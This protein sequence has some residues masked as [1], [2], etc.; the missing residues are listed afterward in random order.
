MEAQIASFR[1]SLKHTYGNQ[2]VL[3]IESSETKESAEKFVGKN[4][5]YAT[6]GTKVIKGTITRPHGV[7]G[8]VLAR[9]ER[10]MP[11]QSL[12][13]SVKIL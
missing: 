10:G 6:E 11:G 2:M 12:G 9:F 3:F 8:K 4:V 1:R 5:E 7:K 13:R